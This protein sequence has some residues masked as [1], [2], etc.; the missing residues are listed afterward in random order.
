MYISF[1]DLSK[2]IFECGRNSGTLLT[3]QT[4]IVDEKLDLK[5]EPH[6]IRTQC[7]LL[8]ITIHTHS[9]GRGITLC[10]SDWRCSWHGRSTKAE[11]RGPHDCRRR[12]GTSY[13]I[14][15]YSSNYNLF[16]VKVSHLGRRTSICLPAHW[17]SM[18]HRDLIWRRRETPISWRIGPSCTY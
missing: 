7:C 6:I 1:S 13:D 5:V 9:P 11:S 18:P 8:L 10:T 17:V 2:H 3:A 15:C 16:T 4:T 14:W 12:R